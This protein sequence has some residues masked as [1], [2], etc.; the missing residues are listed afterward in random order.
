VLEVRPVGKRSVPGQHADWDQKNLTLHS[1]EYT[2]QF[3]KKGGLARWHDRA[4][5]CQWC[6]NESEFPMGTYIYEMPGWEKIKEFASRVHTNSWDETPGYFNRREYTEMTQFGPVGGSNAKITPEITPFYARVTVEANCPNRNVPKRRSG[7]A[8]KY[9]TTFTTYRGSRDLHV[10]VELFGKR[11]TF[12][13]EA[14]YAVFPISGEEPWVLVDRIAQYL[15][16]ADELVDKV[17]AAHMAVHRGVRVEMSHAGLNFYS[18]DAP[19][20]GFGKP[21]AYHFDDDGDYDN[22]LLYANLFNNC[23][24]TN[25]AQWQS[26][27]FTYDFVMRP[28][29]NDEWDGSLARG[30]AE[31]FQPLQACV[32]KGASDEPSRSLLKIEPAEVQLITIK[33]AEFEAGTVIRLWNSD[34][35]D[36]T[37][38][39][40]LPTARRGDRLFACDALERPG[41]KPIDVSSTGEAKLRFRP[42]EIKTLLLK[43]RN[44]R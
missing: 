25:F 44:G 33:P 20:I 38:T 29:G 30:G 21:G 35:D 19:L 43:E 26:G 9:R 22:G 41:R 31:V 32:I 4:R 24:G 17:N 23:W 7:D 40:T 14:G 2:L 6:S 42:N 39:I 18:L 8:K 15:D 36:V 13:A 16:P 27:D 3:H 28:T 11:A 34:V 12:A 5:S 10:R 37:A 1:E